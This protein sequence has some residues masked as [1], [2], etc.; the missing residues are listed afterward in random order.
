MNTTNLKWQELEPY[1]QMEEL[2]KCMDAWEAKWARKNG[3]S[4]EH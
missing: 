1:E 3:D 4:D 2:Q